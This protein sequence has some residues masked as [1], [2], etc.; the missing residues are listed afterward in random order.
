MD[1]ELLTPRLAV[2]AATELGRYVL[3]KV[4]VDAGYPPVFCIPP[5]QLTDLLQLPVTVDAWLLDGSAADNDELLVQ[6]AEADVPFL[7]FD[8]EPPPQYAPHFSLWS[9]RLLDKIEELIGSIGV[10]HAI[11]A[12]PAAVWVLAAS[13]GGPAAVT[14]FLAALTPGLPIAFVYAQHIEAPFD[15]VLTASLCRRHSHLSS[16]LCEGEQRLRS[17]QILIMPVSTQVRFLPFYR[18]VVSRQPWDGPYQPAIDQ[19]VAELARLYQ[20]RC[21]VILFS[22]LCDDGAFGCRRVHALGGRVWV[23]QPDTCISPDMPNAALATGV[24]SRQGTPLELAQ[25]LNALHGNTQGCALN[26]CDHPIDP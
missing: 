19:V 16:V 10:I 11:E 2:V 9:Q 1:T 12:A 7:I 22:G 13:T 4:L 8:D 26:A 18:T 6:I 25:A 5:S 23:Q 21:G 3:H 15:A 14:E 24:V 20:N 17:G